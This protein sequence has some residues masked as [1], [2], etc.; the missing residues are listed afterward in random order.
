VVVV[1]VAAVVAAVVDVAVVFVAAVDHVVVP[2]V[3]AVVGHASKTRIEKREC[4]NL[5]EDTSITNNQPIDYPD[6]SLTDF[7]PK[8]HRPRSNHATEKKLDVMNKRL[9]F[10]HSLFSSNFDEILTIKC[11]II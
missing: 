11:R 3:A 8:P 7:L 10:L 5:V 4:R 2:A 9:K 6:A 1:V